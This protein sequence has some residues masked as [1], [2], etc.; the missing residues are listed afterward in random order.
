[1]TSS[2]RGYE[3]I[4]A[5]DPVGYMPPE[6][7]RAPGHRSY[8]NYA[9]PARTPSPPAAPAAHNYYRNTLPTVAPA[10]TVLASEPAMVSAPRYTEPAN[11]ADPVAHEAVNAGEPELKLLGTT[12]IPQLSEAIGAGKLFAPGEYAEANKAALAQIQQY[13]EQTHMVPPTE[14]PKQQQQQQQQ[15]LA[16]KSSYEAHRVPQNATRLPQQQQQQFYEPQQTQKQATRLIGQSN[17]TAAA[18]RYC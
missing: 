12:T 11:Y 4:S 3:I 18:S 7:E 15:R 14:P 17:A 16:S 10:P 1:M 5:P 8:A 13:L 9:E 6:P 2:M